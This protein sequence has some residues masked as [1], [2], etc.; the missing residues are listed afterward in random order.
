[1]SHPLHAANDQG[2][3]GKSAQAQADVN[4]VKH[5]GSSGSDTRRLDPM[6]V[7][8]PFL[9]RPKGVKAA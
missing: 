8:M 6:P 1:M 5:C 4:D 9:F 3:Q 2:K 7:K